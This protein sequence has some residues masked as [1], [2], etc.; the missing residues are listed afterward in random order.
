MGRDY[1]WDKLEFKKK[2]SLPIKRVCVCAHV[3]IK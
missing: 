3:S 2:A 1:V